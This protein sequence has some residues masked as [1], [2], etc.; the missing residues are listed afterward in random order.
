MKMP[1]LLPEMMTPPVVFAVQK[2]YQIMVP[3]KHDTLFWVIVDGKRYSDHINGIMR[4]SVHVH[5]VHVPMDA[6]DRA[7][8]YTVCYRKI[9]ERKP[10]FTTTEDELSV[11]YP[12]KPVGYGKPLHIYQLADTH[13][14]YDASVEA[15][16]FFN[17]DLD[18]L[19][20]NGDIPDHGGD[21]KNYD[22]ILRL[23]GEIT[24]GQCPT[25]F[26]R[27]NHDT[28]GFYA[29]NFQDYTPT[30]GGKSYYTFRLG[31]VWGMILD[32][33]E[34]KR[35]NRIEYGHTAAFE[36]FRREE[37]GY[38]ENVIRHADSEYREDGVEYRLVIAHAPFS[39]QEESPF[40]IEEPL[41]R[42]WLHFLK[43]QIY[44]DLMLS[45]HLHVC[46]YSPVGGPRDHLGQP[47][48]VVIG[49]RPVC[50]HDEEI[51]DMEGTAI[52]LDG[53]KA[54]ICFTN[55]KKEILQ[56]YHQDL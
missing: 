11:E 34:D 28:R 16:A 21:P 44:P 46:E 52:V 43:E 30:D 15:G 27:G 35:D 4:S 31:P 53:K 50:S 10:Y 36:E 6:L 20:L 1:E 14:N 40:D 54:V 12:F 7:G 32:C 42:Q 38:I 48:P 18:F 45:G 51:V 24:K 22:L 13:G 26:A 5:R 56:E 55:R 9:I 17:D 37:T 3:V 25:V 19:I 49:S 8:K 39:F 23:A 47:C 29:E 33:G 41:Y 2:E